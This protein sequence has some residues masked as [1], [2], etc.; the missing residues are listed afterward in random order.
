LPADPSAHRDSRN[1]RAATR[2]ADGKRF[3]PQRHRQPGGRGTNSMNGPAGVDPLFGS[4]RGS[5]SAAAFGSA[6]MGG[7]AGFGRGSL[8][9]SLA[10]RPALSGFPIVPEPPSQAVLHATAGGSVGHGSFSGGGIG[11][12]IKTEGVYRRACVSR[13]RSLSATTNS[14]LGDL[15]AFFSDVGTSVSSCCVFS[16]RSPSSS[17]IELSTQAIFGMHR[18]ELGSLA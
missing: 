2:D 8:D 6:M 15:S 4:L 17:K 9:S 3:A 13:M 14:W 11:L 7:G 5:G 12:T 18:D 10:A 16:V 1:G